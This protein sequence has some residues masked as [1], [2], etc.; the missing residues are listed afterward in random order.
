MVERAYLVGVAGPTDSE[1]DCESLLDELEELVNTLRIG[2]VGKEQVRMR[3]PQAR[4]LLGSGKMESVVERAREIRAD[5][6]VFEAELSPAQQRN[7]E[8]ASGMC[9]I[10]RQEVILDIFSERAQTREAVL[11]VELARAEHSLPRLKNAWTHLSRQRGGGGVTQR[12]EGEAQIELDARMVRTRIAKLKKELE[13]VIRHRDTQRKQR[14]R[15]PVPTAAIVGYT[16]AGKSTLLNAL[17]GA[18]VLSEDKLFATLDPTTRQMRLPSGQKLLL[19]D[20]VGFVRRLPHKLVEAFK[21]TLEEAVLADFLVHVVDISNPEYEQ[22]L[23]TTNAVLKELGADEKRMITV[24]NKLDRVPAVRLPKGLSRP[25]VPVSA[26]TGEGLLELTAQFEQ[27]LED[28]M[29][30]MDLL[31]P[32]DRYELISQLHQQGT[33]KEE[34]AGDEGLR[35][36]ANVPNRIRSQYEEFVVS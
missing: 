6:L 1:S 15:V 31:I 33:V 17:T 16:N 36:V 28:R 5:C 8:A 20:T 27:F 14:Q 2:I 10:D 30:T 7:W 26:M 9:V 19:T 32:F 25:S 35:L 24:F 23:V 21:A 12:G 4:Y 3:K 13:A 29:V 18:R 22:Q 34:K 11:Q